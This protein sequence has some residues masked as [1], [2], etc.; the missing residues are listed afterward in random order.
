MRGCVTVFGK[1]SFKGKQKEIMEAAVKGQDILVVAPTGMGKVR[2]ALLVLARRKA[3]FARAV[4]LL[5]STGRSRRTRSNSRR[6]TPHLSVRLPYIY[7][8]S[9]CLTLTVR[10]RSSDE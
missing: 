9:V 3:E 1:S 7:F 6:N 5:S 4:A 2:R 8:S 10:S